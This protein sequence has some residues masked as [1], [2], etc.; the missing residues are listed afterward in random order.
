M[1]DVFVPVDMDQDG[2]IDWVATRGNS[3]IYDGVFWLEQVRTAEPKPAFT[4]GR[5]EDSRALPLPPENWI[6]TYETEMTF[7][8]PNKA[9]HE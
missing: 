8:P 1:Y 6:D 9:G 7:T 3:G 2:D 4:A 5:S